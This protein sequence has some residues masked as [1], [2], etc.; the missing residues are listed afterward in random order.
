MKQCQASAGPNVIPGAF[1]DVMLRYG[2]VVR[3]PLG[4][5]LLPKYAASSPRGRIEGDDRR[6]GE[7][8][9]AFIV[10]YCSLE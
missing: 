10:P 4:H 1:D 7:I 5:A 6:L 3:V 8:Q 9:L 2:R